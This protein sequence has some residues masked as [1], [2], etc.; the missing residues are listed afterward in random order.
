MQVF[1]YFVTGMLCLNKLEANEETDQN[2]IK[3]QLEKLAA[4]INLLQGDYS[5]TG[6]WMGFGVGEGAI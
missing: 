5:Y 4:E 3:S 1:H 6:V 2:Q